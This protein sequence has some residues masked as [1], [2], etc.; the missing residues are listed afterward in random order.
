MIQGKFYGNTPTIE[1]TMTWKGLV[2]SPEF[3]L[4]TGFTGS[5]WVSPEIADYLGLKIAGSQ[6]V[7]VAGDKI[8]DVPVSLAIVEMESIKMPVTVLVSGNLL[9]AGIGLFTTFAYKT[10]VDCV[11]RTAILEKV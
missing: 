6:P 5:L 7:R 11:N 2:Q 8:E 10:I 1:V 3:I 9:L 4:D